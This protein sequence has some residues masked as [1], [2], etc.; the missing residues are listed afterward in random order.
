[1]SCSIKYKSSG[2]K[3]LFKVFN[4][5]LY[6]RSILISLFDYSGIWSAPYRN[7]GCRV[8]QVESKLGFDLFKWNYKAIRPELV[9][10]ILAA[11]P[12]TDFA[13]SG[14]QYWKEKDKDGRTAASVKLIRKTLEIIHYFR[15]KFWALENP[16]GRLNVVVPELKQFGPW[17][18]EPYWFG[19]PW[20]KKTGLWG[21]FNKPKMEKV[22]PI[23]F[24]KQGSWTQLLGGKSEQ[25]KELRS[26]TPPGFAKAF[27]L[28]NPYTSIVKTINRLSIAA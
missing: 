25:T 10:G 2:I 27:Y 13:N 17:Y 12:C 1:M 20:S 11:P 7:A 18:F 15:P 19:N 24:S 4:Q 14:A 6:S 3:E 21:Q 23:K 8:L 28:A 9:L 26:I 16:V 5:A 22:T